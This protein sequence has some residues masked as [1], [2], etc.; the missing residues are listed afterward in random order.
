MIYEALLYVFPPLSY[1]SAILGSNIL[2]KHFVLKK[3]PTARSSFRVR[4]TFSHPDEHLL[5]GCLIMFLSGGSICK[6][7]VGFINYQK[8]E[9][10]LYL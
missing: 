2:F 1:T 8:D 6:Q 3:N 7:D 5:S 9:T 10:G 4:Y